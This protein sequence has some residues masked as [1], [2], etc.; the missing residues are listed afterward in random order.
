[1]SHEH[2]CQQPGRRR[3]RAS[4][5]TLALKSPHRVGMY[6]SLV[7]T[8]DQQSSPQ[9]KRAPAPRPSQECLVLLRIVLISAEGKLDA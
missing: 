7:E 8:R 3:A 9:Q 6:D 4:G 5:A 2:P 1:M